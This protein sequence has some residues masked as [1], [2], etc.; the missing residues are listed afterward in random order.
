[1][2]PHVCP[3]VSARAR[4]CSRIDFGSILA[5]NWLVVTPFFLQVDDHFCSRDKGGDSGGDKLFIKRRVAVT[6]RDNYSP[7]G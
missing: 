5:L 4:K 1:M 3:S 2:C 7:L 6:S